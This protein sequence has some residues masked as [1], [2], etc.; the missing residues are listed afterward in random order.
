MV[1][2]DRPLD[3]K[4]DRWFL[5]TFDI[6][7]ATSKE[8]GGQYGVVM[9]F[10]ERGFS[11]PDHQH[12]KEDSGFLVLDGKL[13]MQ[14]GDG[15]KIQ[16]GPNEFAWAPRGKRHW[17]R[18]ESET[19]RFLEILSPGGF[20]GFHLAVSEPAKTLGMP[21]ANH[22]SPDMKTIKEASSKY[23]ATVFGPKKD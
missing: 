19:A 18:V 16:V 22:P 1:K 6:I 10:A 3:A 2:L 14:V 5:G 15:P 13:T 9:R 20:E 23:G 17:F 8:T 4:R 12:S 11:P 21:P 7:A